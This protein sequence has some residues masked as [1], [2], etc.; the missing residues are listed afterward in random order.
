MK[1]RIRRLRKALQQ[2]L[3]DIDR[4]IPRGSRDTSRSSPPRRHNEDLMA[5]V[6]GV[7]P[8]IART[9][10]RREVAALAGLA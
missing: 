7:G 10:D 8:A 5:S 9:L 4:E 1:R 6:P 2:A 3:T